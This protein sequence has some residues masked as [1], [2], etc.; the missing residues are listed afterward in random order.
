MDLSFSLKIGGWSKLESGFPHG[1]DQRELSCRCH[2][3]MGPVFSPRLAYS[4]TGVC[5]PD[6]SLL[7]PC[8]KAFFT[9]SF[10]SSRLPEPASLSRLYFC[11]LCCIFPLVS[12]KSA[13][14][15]LQTLHY[16]FIELNVS[17]FA[18]FLISST[19]NPPNTAL[20]FFKEFLFS[21]TYGKIGVTN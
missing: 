9:H 21:P 19:F 15:I 12:M 3:L 14:G 6:S 8:R 16:I 5:V 1:R 13:L 7:A 10:I 20:G 4:G 17:K 18:G 11:L 2:P